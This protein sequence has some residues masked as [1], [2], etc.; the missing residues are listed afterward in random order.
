MAW[1]K[2]QGDLEKTGFNDSDGPTKLIHLEQALKN[3]EKQE[4]FGNIKTMSV[5]EFAAYSRVGGAING[6]AKD[7][8]ANPVV[9][10][11]NRSS[12]G[13]HTGGIHTDDR[14]TIK[15]NRK[16]D[17]ETCVYFR[18]VVNTACRALEKNEVVLPLRLAS[19]NEARRFERPINQFVFKLRHPPR[20]ESG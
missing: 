8:K 18:R 10:V 5:R 2:Y 3:H 11:R 20:R 19:M 14:L 1:L 6:G 7:K 13:I 9:I 4:V 16:L 17:R 12:G 15:I